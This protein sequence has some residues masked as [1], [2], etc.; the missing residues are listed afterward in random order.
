M[1]FCDWPVSLSNVFTVHLCY[2]IGQYLLLFF[3]K[4]AYIFF[5]HP[6]IHQAGCF[7]ILARVA[8]AAIN[9]HVQMPFQDP[10]FSS[11][12][13]VHRSGIARSCSTSISNFLRTLHAVYCSSDTISVTVALHKDSDF[14]IS[15]PM[16]VIFFNSVCLNKYEVDTLSHCG[17]YFSDNQ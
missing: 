5:I 6:S 4:A 15:S 8:D 2:H 10:V 17:F 1:S 14:F 16:L 13:Y 12:G 7:R 3:F 9:M 11:P